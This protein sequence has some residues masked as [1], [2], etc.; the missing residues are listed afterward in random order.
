MNLNKKSTKSDQQKTQ[1][2]DAAANSLIFKLFSDMDE[3]DLAKA[4]KVH[5]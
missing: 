1:V 5:H 2:V 4:N 3:S